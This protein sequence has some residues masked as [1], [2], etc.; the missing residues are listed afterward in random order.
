MR[1]DFH[2]A[3]RARDFLSRRLGRPGGSRGIV[4]PSVDARRSFDGCGRGFALSAPSAR[5]LFVLGLLLSAFVALQCLL[6]LKTTVKIGADEGFELAKATLCLKG[7]HLYTDV[8]NDQPPLYTFLVTKII[9]HLS[10]SVLGPRLLTVGLAMLLLASVFLLSWRVQGLWVAALA[11]GWLMASP[12]FLELSCSVMQEIP[13]LALVAAALAVLA[14]GGRSRWYAAEIAAGILFALGLQVK[15]IGVIYLPL[16]GCILWLRHRSALPPP[17]AHDG[18][19]AH[20]ESVNL[21]RLLTESLAGAALCFMMSQATSFVAID[22][23][24]DGGAYLRHF[25]QSWSSHFAGVRSLEHGSPADHPFDWMVLLR[26]WDTTV[27]AMLGAVLCWR[28]IRHTRI[29][30]LPLLWLVLTLL[31]FGWHKPWWTYYYVH[32]ALPLCWCAAIGIASV[33]RWA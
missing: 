25:E 9:Q 26:N 3:S 14:L 13:G 29:A 15:L 6:P 10:P 22:W 11:T 17:A 8:W 21:A 31:V 28:Q 4:R 30:L 33:G 19:T 5:P 20:R 12:G 7:Y 27:P 2:H 24:I 18:G 23:L 1:Q 16:A 32:T